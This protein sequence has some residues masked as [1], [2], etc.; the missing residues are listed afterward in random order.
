MMEYQGTTADEVQSD[1]TDKVDV[2]SG[3][4]IVIAPEGSFG[5][6]VDDSSE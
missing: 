5:V 1:S 3:G 6:Q 4:K 2:I